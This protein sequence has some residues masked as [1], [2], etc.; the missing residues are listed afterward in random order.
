MLRA[1]RLTDDGGGG[2]CP[3]RG[4]TLATVQCWFTNQDMVQALLLLLLLENAHHKIVNFLRM[5]LMDM[6][7]AV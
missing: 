3:D 6:R 1:V 2:A 4:Q 5:P 7:K